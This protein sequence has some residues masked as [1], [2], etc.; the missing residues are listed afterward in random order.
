MNDISRNETSIGLKHLKHFINYRSNA[1]IIVTAAPH[2]HGLQKTSCIDS[3]VQIFN[4]KLH[5]ILKTM[6]NVKIFDINLNRN[7]FTQH[8]LHLNIFGKERMAETI[9]KNIKQLMDKKKEYP[10]NSRLGRKS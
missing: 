5:K 7:N 2:S 4:R 8:G 1:N 6:D 10:H 3:E 9:V